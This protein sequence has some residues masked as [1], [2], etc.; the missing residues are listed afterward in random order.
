MSRRSICAPKSNFLVPVAAPAGS[1]SDVFR[2]DRAGRPSV[3][4]I[5]DEVIE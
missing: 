2:T 4:A 3:L 5:A 1:V